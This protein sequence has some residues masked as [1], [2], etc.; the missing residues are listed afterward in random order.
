[1]PIHVTDEIS[2][3]K[4]VLLHKPGKELEQLVPQYLVQL[5]FDD[6]PYLKAAQYE[7]DYFAN[8]LIKNGIEVLYLEDLMAETIAQSHE[9]KEQ[10]LDDFIDEAGTIAM[11]HKDR[12]KKLLMSINDEKELI[13]KT[14]AGINS[15]SFQGENIGPLVKLISNSNQFILEPI[16]NLYFTRDPFVTIGNGVCINHMYSFTRNRETIYGRYIFNY[17]KDYAGKIPFYYTNDAPYNIEGGDILILNE[18][19][20]A[21]GLS[22]R[23]SPEAVELLSDNIFSN[24][25]SKINTV[26]AFD[27]PNLR[28]YMHLDTVFTQVDKNKFT[29]HPAI[30]D[31]LELYII[32]KVP[33][34]KFTAKKS[35]LSLEDTLKKV[36]NLDECTLIYCGGKDQIASAREQWNDGAN[37]LCIAP[38]VVVTYDRNTITNQILIDNGITV[39]TTLSSEL[40]RGRGGPRCMS[41]PL[42]RE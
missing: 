42:F 2:P 41:M 33:G 34:K 18:N 13:L 1:M 10:F 37:T 27:I 38:G 19:V 4:K 36:L 23:T 32:K 6:I 35:D 22:Q 8:L 31:Y 5:L 28:T 30:L 14:M 12:L 39:L 11:H 7:H 20:L 29:V 25:E 26:L 16:P 9:I 17:H 21:V 24:E 40:S 3:M 15:K